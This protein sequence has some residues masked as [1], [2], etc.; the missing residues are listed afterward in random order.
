MSRDS[1]LELFLDLLQLAAECEALAADLEHTKSLQQ[2][3]VLV[4]A[5]AEAANSVVV[6]D[7]PVPPPPMPAHV[8][9]DENEADALAC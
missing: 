6:V 8:A 4:A 1:F 3:S 2:L 9:T 5:V 7:G